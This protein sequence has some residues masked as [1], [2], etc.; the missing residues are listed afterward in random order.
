MA[1]RR[2]E[3]TCSSL[4]SRRRKVSVQQQQ[5]S[6][7]ACKASERPR[8]WRWNFRARRGEALSLSLSLGCRYRRGSRINIGS[9]PLIPK[10]RRVYEVEFNLARRYDAA[11]FVQYEMRRRAGGGY[12]EKVSLIRGNE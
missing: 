2:A 4:S 11:A 5:E 12:C 7:Y 1:E 10:W 6:W 3:R 8:S 9:R